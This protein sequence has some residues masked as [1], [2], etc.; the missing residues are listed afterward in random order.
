[1]IDFRYLITAA[2]PY[3]NNVPHL[4]HLIS[5][6][7]PA[8]VYS[9]FL[10]LNGKTCVYV[11]G[12]DEYGTTAEIEA[13]KQH[14]TPKELADTNFL[15]TKESYERLDCKPDIFSR[16]SSPEHTKTVQGFYKRIL[17]KGY[18]YKKG[19]DQL[20][21][22]RDR[23]FLAD[24]FVEGTCPYCG[25]ERAKGDQCERCGRVLEP[26]ELKDPCCIICGERPHIRRSEHIFFALSKLQ[27]QLHAFVEGQ[28]H[29]FPNARNFALSWLKEGL[30]DIDI[31][32]DIKWGVPIPGSEGKVFYSWFD[33]PLGYMTFT[34]QLG[35]GSWWRDEKV[36][37]V[38]FIGKDN[39]AF[40]TLFFPGMLMAAGGYILPWQV[41][42]Y[43]FLNWTEGEKFSKSR[44][45]GL[46][47]PQAAEL[48]PADYWRYYLLTILTET[49]DTNFSWD[50]FQSK[51]NVDLN[52]TVGNFVHRTLAFTERFFES[53]IPKPGKYGEADKAALKAIDDSFA[54]ATAHLENIELKSALAD[55][56]NL[57]R[58]GNQY[59]Q[60]KAPWKDAD[61]RPTTVYVA[62]NI[63]HALSVLLEPFIPSSAAKIRGLLNETGKPKWGDAK[64]RVRIGS[65]VGRIEPVFKKI[66][67]KEISA[68]KK[69]Y[70]GKPKSK[71]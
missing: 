12:T 38:H 42:S 71:L 57:A 50:D 46:T 26:A 27:D 45:I 14:I 64:S 53:K 47:V 58:T 52:D 8:D 39:I 49:K 25:Y 51:T 34:N 35:K 66:E 5:T 31:Q 3:I 1:M 36:K 4:G 56:I 7:L 65:R 22:D 68:H 10:K 33:A 21:C 41:A 13:F 63:A 37:L 9:R 32:R 59:I 15:I 16:T 23:R 20:Y 11:C 40:H 24:R 55:V 61:G 48:Y 6:L 62:I 67:E 17:D 18:I 30:V 19:I 2:L 69:R 70:G 60:G 54:K 29:W 43:E 28:R 44:G